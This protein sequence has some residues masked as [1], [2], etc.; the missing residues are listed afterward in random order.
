MHKHGSDHGKR[1]IFDQ[2][3]GPKRQM[4]QKMI[5]DPPGAWPRNFVPKFL[6]K[7]CILGIYTVPKERVTVVKNSLNFFKNCQNM[8]STYPITWPKKL[9][10]HTITFVAYSSSSNFWN[11]LFCLFVAIFW[12]LLFLLLFGL[13]P[14]QNASI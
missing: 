4:D 2:F 5:L 1:N 11:M 12:N 6:V 3:I 10:R 9:E 14:G 8:E 7:I 13:K